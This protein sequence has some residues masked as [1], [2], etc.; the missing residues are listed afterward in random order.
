MPR[1]KHAVV[2]YEIY[3]IRDLSIPKPEHTTGGSRR[4]ARRGG[5]AASGSTVH[6]QNCSPKGQSYP[7]LS[8]APEGRRLNVSPEER[9]SEFLCK[10]M[11]ERN[12][13]LNRGSSAVYHRSI[14][15][16]RI[17]LCSWLLTSGTTHFC[18]CKPFSCRAC[19]GISLLMPRRTLNTKAANN[20]AKG[21]VSKIAK[22]RL[23]ARISAAKRI[24]GICGEQKRANYGNAKGTR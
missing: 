9:T 16:T 2:R 24:P 6:Q 22:M 12:D 23:K 21:L 3:N 10:P 14:S 1:N 17:A 15:G 13:R 19:P 7:A 8:K 18:F 11:E 5:G 4:G 20:M